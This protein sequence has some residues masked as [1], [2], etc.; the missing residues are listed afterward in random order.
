MTAKIILNPYSNRWNAKKRWP[1]AEAALMAA[2][3]DFELAVSEHPHHTIEL[4][5]QAGLVAAGYRLQYQVLIARPFLLT[6]MVLLAASVSLRFFRMGG[7]TK[8]ILGG[9]TAGF[10]LY[11]ISKVT[12][13]LSKAELMHPVAAAWLPV[14][15]GGLTGFVALLY[16]EDG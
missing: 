1:E 3:V 2:A 14:L 11:V 12:E 4:A 13:D 15:T 8:M 10:L 7:V 9:I 5:E 6:A 16:Q